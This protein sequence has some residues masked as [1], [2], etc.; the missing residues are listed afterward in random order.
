MGVGLGQQR[1]DAMTTLQAIWLGAML[2]WTPGL[3]VFAVLLWEEP[4]DEADLGDRFSRVGGRA[5]LPGKKAAAYGHPG[6]NCDFGIASRRSPRGVGRA[7]FR[8]M[9]HPRGLHALPAR[10]R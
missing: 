9:T 8:L 4:L 6:P 3:V 10:L 7:R 2:A 5:S 1:V